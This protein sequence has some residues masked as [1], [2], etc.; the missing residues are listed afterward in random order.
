MRSWTIKANV[1]KMCM[2]LWFDRRSW[3]QV[4]TAYRASDSDRCW[5]EILAGRPPGIL[6]ADPCCVSPMRVS[7]FLPLWIHMG[8]NFIHKF[9]DFKLNIWMSALMHTHTGLTP[10]QIDVHDSTCTCFFFSSRDQKTPTVKKKNISRFLLQL[11]LEFSPSPRICVV[12]TLR[13]DQLGTFCISDAH[14][15]GEAKILLSSRGRAPASSL[16]GVPPDSR[17]TLIHAHLAQLGWCNTRVKWVFL[18][19]DCLIMSKLW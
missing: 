14:I 11:E 3:R 8:V 7:P 13:S 5:E 19:M 18:L 1:Q 17:N 9:Q 6:I 16:N 4:E 2:L 10:G 12:L 15:K